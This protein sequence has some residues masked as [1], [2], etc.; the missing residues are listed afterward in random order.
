[1]SGGGPAWIFAS[2]RPPCR[3]LA[4]LALILLAFAPAAYADDA[5]WVAMPPEQAARLKAL[6][7]EYPLLV[8][9]NALLKQETA[10][11]KKLTELQDRLLALKDEEIA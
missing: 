4:A 5:E 11:L 2:L 6:A 10:A 7:D 3:H 9:E 8:Q 1:M